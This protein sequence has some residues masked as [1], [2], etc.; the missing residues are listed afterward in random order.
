MSHHANPFVA[1]GLAQAKCDTAKIVPPS[2]MGYVP[3]GNWKA[4]IV[5]TRSIRR[6]VS[7]TLRVPSERGRELIGVM[8]P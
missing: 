3:P 6:L 2:R 5:I 4:G 1:V 7:Q 8:L